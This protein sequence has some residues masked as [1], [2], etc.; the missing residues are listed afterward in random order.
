M[1]EIK[2]AAGSWVIGGHRDRFCGLSFF[3][4]YPR[5]TTRLAKDSRIKGVE[6]ICPMTI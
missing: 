3:A 6:V 5:E 4:C 2:W 1:E